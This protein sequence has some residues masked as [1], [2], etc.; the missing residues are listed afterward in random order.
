MFWLT[1]LGCEVVPETNIG[2][3]LAKPSL[4]MKEAS[5][6]FV[7]LSARRFLLCAKNSVSLVG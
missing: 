5:L 7:S 3:N 6:A 4:T 2:W 1:E